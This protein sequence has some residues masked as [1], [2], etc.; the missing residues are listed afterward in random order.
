MAWGGSEE[1]E[2]E[3]AASNPNAKNW[4]DVALK[5]V[6]DAMQAYWKERPEARAQPNSVSK[7]GLFNTLASDYKQHHHALIKKSSMGWSAELHL[8]L[9]E[10]A[11][12]VTR[13]TD[14]IDWWGKH[15][16]IY[17]T[18]FLM[19][20]D[21]CRIPASS[22]PCEHLFSAGGQIATD[23]RSRLGSDQFEQ[24]QILKHGW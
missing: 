23:R 12:N 17:P 11:E 4:H 19:A 6:K 24:L 9:S 15:C 14:V 16:L 22:V 1:Q 5:V 7:Q 2:A 21:V 13:D 20:Q 18:L 8:Y 3:C 10:I